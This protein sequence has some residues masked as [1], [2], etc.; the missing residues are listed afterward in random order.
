MTPEGIFCVKVWEEMCSCFNQTKGQ[1]I[2]KQCKRWR[3]WWRWRSSGSYRWS[4]RRGCGPAAPCRR[5]WPCAGTARGTRHKARG[6][7]GAERAPWRTRRPSQTEPSP[8]ARRWSPGRPSPA[9]E[10][11]QRQV[12]ERVTTRHGSRPKV[13]PVSELRQIR[14]KAP[15]QLLSGSEILFQRKS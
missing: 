7:C 4:R 15:E 5:C 1:L 3:C 11:K 6:A 9:L 2:E 8:P 12:I 13:H 14:S 10:Q